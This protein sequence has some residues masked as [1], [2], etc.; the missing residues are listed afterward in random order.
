MEIRNIYDQIEHRHIGADY[1]HNAQKV[2]YYESK[3]ETITCHRMV[4]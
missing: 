3:V 4:I 1:W 2:H